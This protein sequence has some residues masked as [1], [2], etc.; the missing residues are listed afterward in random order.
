MSVSIDTRKAY[1]TRQ[2]GDLIVV[3][4]WVDD[5]RSMILLPAHRVG[6]PWFIVKDSAAYTWDDSDPTNVS[7]VVRKS[8][9]A[10][11]VLG[12]EPN[13]TNCRRVAGIIIDGI[14]DLVRMPSSPPTEYYKASFG[15]MQ[16]VADGSLIA[17]EDIRL[18]KEGVRYG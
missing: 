10:C 11:E 12:I 4:T 17:E 16:V 2:H 13:P 7:Q 1:L 6:A 15:R 8:I 3:F 9:K 14:G 5:E 18:E